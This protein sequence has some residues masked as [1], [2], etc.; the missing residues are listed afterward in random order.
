[1]WLFYYLDMI[2]G[3]PFSEY[4]KLGITPILKLFQLRSLCRSYLIYCHHFTVSITLMVKYKLG[5]IPVHW[6]IVVKSALESIH[7]AEF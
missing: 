7:S 3:I 5:T 1:M 2:S 6:K 4:I